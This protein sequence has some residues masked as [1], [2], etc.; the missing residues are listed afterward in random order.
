MWRFIR[1]IFMND[2]VKPEQLEKW[3]TNLS[4]ERCKQMAALI[5]AACLRYN[6]KDMDEF[7][8][9][10]A[11]CLQESAEFTHKTENMNYRAETLVKVWP[12]RFPTIESAAPFAHNPQKLANKVYGFRMGNTLPDDGW[13]FRGG[14][15]IGLTG[16]EVYTKYANYLKIKSVG[17]VADLVRS[18]DYYALD[19]AF[20]FFYELKGLR[21]ESVKD[22]FIGIVKSI[23]GGTIG[24]KD[25][26]FYYERIIA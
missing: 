25:R 21:D 16:R 7:D 3:T 12:S 22:D 23:N 19:S 8:E 9:F 15:F 5:N 6:V 10:L 13:R 2:I 26:R 18:D 24:L 17:E 4:F 14:G 20:W 11:N 1:K